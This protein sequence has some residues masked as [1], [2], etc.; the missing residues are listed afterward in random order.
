M[1]V[2]ITGVPD[3][4]LRHLKEVAAD[5]Q[6]AHNPDGTIPVPMEAVVEFGLKMDVVPMPGLINA[7]G[8]TG[9]VTRD[10]TEIRVDQSLCEK[11]AQYNLALAREVAHLI[12]H[13]PLYQQWTFTTT[14]EWKD[15]I[16]AIPE[17]TRETLQTQA[18]I[19]AGLMLVPSDALAKHF[20]ETIARVP[21]TVSIQ[22]LSEKGRRIIAEPLAATF[23]V[24][25]NVMMARI[26]S[27]RL[28]DQS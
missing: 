8:I 7:F 10:F 9:W 20:G 27:E 23:S 12:L 13:A 28:W 14:G 15:T 25:V 22:G 11:P 1:D 16:T 21:A 6:R 17:G 18:S 24:P 3:L 2:A 19:L 4:P 5:F 26:N